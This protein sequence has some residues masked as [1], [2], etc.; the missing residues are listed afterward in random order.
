MASMPGVSHAVKARREGHLQESKWDWTRISP[1]EGICRRPGSLGRAESDTPTVVNKGTGTSTTGVAG[2]AVCPS[3]NNN[4]RKRT[5]QQIGM[6]IRK[7]VISLTK[8]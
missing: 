1:E 3:S 6:K 5:N 7:F 2:V 4:V 8:M